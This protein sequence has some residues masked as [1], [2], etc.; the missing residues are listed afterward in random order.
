MLHNADL[1]ATDDTAIM[2][3]IHQTRTAV[4]HRL[5]FILALLTAPAHA[6]DTRVYDIELL[7]FEN[8]TADNSD[9]QWPMRDDKQQVNGFTSVQWRDT[10]SSQLKKVVASLNRSKSYRPLLHVIWRQSL[11]KKGRTRFIKLP[12]KTASNTDFVT[13]TASLKLGR[14]L[15]LGLD[16]T[17]HTVQQT[18]MIGD[19]FSVGGAPVTITL[20]QKRRM[21]SKELHYFDNP[22][23][24]ALAIITPVE[25]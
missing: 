13:G 5:L 12:E 9:E 3:P 4:L 16:L 14:Y 17:L 21:R 2:K 10:A 15:H 8:L 1:L 18:V 20:K 19:D 23:L 7:V 11:T 24:G 25:E 6:A 22:R